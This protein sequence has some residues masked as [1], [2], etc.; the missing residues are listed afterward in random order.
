MTRPTDWGPPS[1][2]E[3][4]VYVCQNERTS[5]VRVVPTLA[6]S[7]TLPLPLPLSSTRKE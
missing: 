2:E 6:L 5:G 1:E 3:E 7:H 4:E